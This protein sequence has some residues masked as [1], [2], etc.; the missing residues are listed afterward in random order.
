MSQLLPA[1][2]NA[3]LYQLTT[4]NRIGSS[5]GTM[6]N[7]FAL[8]GVEY[9]IVNAISLSAE[10]RLGYNL[11][12]PSDEEI[13][14]NAPG[15]VTETTKGTSTHDLYLNSPGFLTLAIYF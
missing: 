6:V 7:F 11:L 5:A 14:S 13:S 1:T 2:G 9:F 3:P 8:M 12:S 10:Y 15:F 4:K